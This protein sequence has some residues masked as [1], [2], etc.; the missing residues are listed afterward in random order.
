MKTRI[1]LTFDEHEF[2][3]LCGAARAW[4][5]TCKQFILKALFEAN[6]RCFSSLRQRMPRTRAWTE[7]GKN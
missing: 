7:Q 5:L 6:P 4:D 1:V 3:A 2:A